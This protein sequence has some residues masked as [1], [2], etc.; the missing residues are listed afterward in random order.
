MMTAINMEAANM[1]RN[2]IDEY[3]KYIKYVVLKDPE[4]EDEKKD[5]E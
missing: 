5:E 2:S 1:M 4:E 3:R